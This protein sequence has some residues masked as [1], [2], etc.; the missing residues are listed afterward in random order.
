MD[1]KLA[2]GWCVEVVVENEM[3]EHYMLEVKVSL[4][5][6]LRT[7]LK[8]DLIT[9]KLIIAAND[10]PHRAYSRLEQFTEML[11]GSKELRYL[12]Q[13]LELELA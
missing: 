1:P 5:N 2:T 4:Q 8:N 9:L 3:V 11:E 13:A 10:A 7:Q 6:Y 12:Q